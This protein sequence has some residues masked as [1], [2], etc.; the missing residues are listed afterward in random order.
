MV[1]TLGSYQLVHMPRLM[2]TTCRTAHTGS[3]MSAHSHVHALAWRA[4]PC[5]ARLLAL[6][7]SPHGQ[8]GYR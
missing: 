1:V 8:A 3:V 2:G 4:G 6:Q 7:P 5:W